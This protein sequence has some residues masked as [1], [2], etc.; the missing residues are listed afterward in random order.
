MRQRRLLVSTLISAGVVFNPWTLAWLFSAH[1]YLSVPTVWAVLVIDALLIGFGLLLRRKSSIASRM[2]STLLQY[3]TVRV[4]SFAAYC[5]IA[6]IALMEVAVRLYAAYE[7]GPWHLLYGTRFH[8]KHGDDR[9]VSQMDGRT[10]RYL[11]YTPYQEIKDKDQNQNYFAPRI[12]NLGFRGKD[13][14]L[15]KTPGITRIVTLGASST[16]G[17]GNNDDETYPV[18]LEQALNAA[19]QPAKFEVL[20]MGIPHNTSSQI[21]ELMTEEVLP[22][23]PDVVTFYEG[24]NNTVVLKARFLAR[25]EARLMLVGFLERVLEVTVEAFGKE[26]VLAHAAAKAAKFYNDLAAIASLCKS[27][28]IR[29]I[30]ISQQ[31]KSH[32]VP[33]DRIKGVSYE[34]EYQ[35]ILEKLRTQRINTYELA[36]AIHHTF[37]QRLPA[38]AL[39]Q[40]V[41]YVEGIG[42]LDGDRDQLTSW[43]HLTPQGNGILGRAIAQAILRESSQNASIDS[44]R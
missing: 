37:M 21:L 12:N 19:G 24:V 15:Q 35:L 23:K 20:N 16:F 18:Y 39:K 41:E 42:S 44:S 22:L 32:L 7:L 9:T 31:A 34:Q 4:V 8:F 43:V 28:G 5:T 27:N 40:G 29:F 10:I 26:D 36:F 3:R 38:W 25:L 13:F 30:V 17:F 14:T 2:V 6:S 11:K 1:G 33:K